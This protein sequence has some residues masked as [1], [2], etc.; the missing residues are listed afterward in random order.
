MGLQLP[1]EAERGF[2][3][4]YPLVWLVAVV[5]PCAITSYGSYRSARAEADAKASAGYATLLEAQKKLEDAFE[6]HLHAD[7]KVTAQLTS[8]V[9]VLKQMVFRLYNFGREST[10]GRS[11]LPSQPPTAAVTPERHFP[12]YQA[13]DLPLTLDDAQR[14]V[15]AK[16]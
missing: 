15:N 12:A 16:K 1:D 8:D 11:R 6:A 2:I 13:Q 3:S 14:Q 5:L 7:E 10:M 9:S 4:K